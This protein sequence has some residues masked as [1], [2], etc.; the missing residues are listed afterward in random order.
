M[1]KGPKGRSVDQFR[2][3]RADIARLYLQGRTQ[4]EI[5][6]QLGLSRQQIGQGE[7]GPC[8]ISWR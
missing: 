6:T 2:R 8:W 4:A 5:G 1:S 7:L 3:D